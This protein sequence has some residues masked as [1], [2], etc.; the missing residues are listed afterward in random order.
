MTES[1][2]AWTVYNEN[3]SDYEQTILLYTITLTG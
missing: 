2:D 3:K 1:R